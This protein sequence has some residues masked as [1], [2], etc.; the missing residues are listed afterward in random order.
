M[1]FK[2]CLVSGFLGGR[3]LRDRHSACLEEEL[4]KDV[5]LPSFSQ[6][7]VYLFMCAQHMFKL[8]AIFSLL[9]EM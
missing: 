6:F 7:C 2:A 8:Q 3:S 9:G 4:V 1:T 5:A